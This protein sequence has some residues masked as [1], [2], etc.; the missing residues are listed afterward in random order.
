[1]NHGNTEAEKTTDNAITQT[2]NN[3]NSNDLKVKKMKRGEKTGIRGDHGT[4]HST[5]RTH[6]CQNWCL[7]SSSSVR[8][9]TTQASS[10]L[11]RV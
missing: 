11:M 9:F 3:K 7:F 1:M 4:L 2:R 10:T 6:D 8:V 5:A